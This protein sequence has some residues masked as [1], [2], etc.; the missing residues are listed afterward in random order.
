MQDKINIF[1]QA[2]QSRQLDPAIIGHYNDLMS[3]IIQYI[4]QLEDDTLT[5]SLALNAKTEQ[6]DKLMTYISM[7]QYHKNG[8]GTGKFLTDIDIHKYIK[9]TDN[10]YALMRKALNY[11]N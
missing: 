9:P 5:L 6:A 10:Y 8:R 3:Q 7:V 11:D 2:L 1:T 4:D